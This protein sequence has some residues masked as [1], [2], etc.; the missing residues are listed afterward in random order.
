MATVLDA[1]KRLGATFHGESRLTSGVSLVQ[2]A[3][4]G[5]RFAVKGRTP[6]EIF[7]VAALHI[8]ELMGQKDGLPRETGREAARAWLELIRKPSAGKREEN[9]DAE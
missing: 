8:G 4:K 6:D 9:D 5:T 3:Y 1:I 2:L 7:E